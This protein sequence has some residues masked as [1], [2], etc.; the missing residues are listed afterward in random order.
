MTYIM[1]ALELE[2]TVKNYERRDSTGWF[3]SDFSLLFSHVSNSINVPGCLFTIYE[4]MS[5]FQEVC[6]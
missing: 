3:V 5:S 4:F 6:F 2:D 1:E